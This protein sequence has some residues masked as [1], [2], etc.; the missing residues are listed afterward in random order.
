MWNHQV[1]LGTVDGANIFHRL[2]SRWWIH[3]S[4]ARISKL[5]ALELM[6]PLFGRSFS[7][8]GPLLW[9]DFMRWSSDGRGPEIESEWVGAFTSQFYVIGMVVFVDV[10]CP[11]ILMFCSH[12]EIYKSDLGY[13]FLAASR[14]AELPCTCQ[15]ITV[16]SSVTRKDAASIQRGVVVW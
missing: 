4:T 1:C 7:F 12:S 10:I 13:W 3:W 15:C 2:Q 11:C 5:A 14:F 16:S 9:S 8:L 6:F